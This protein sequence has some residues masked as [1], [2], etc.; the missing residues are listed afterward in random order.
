MKLYSK[1]VLE[2]A[3]I[4]Y[5]WIVDNSLEFMDKIKDKGI[6][7]METFDFSTLYPALTSI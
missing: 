1:T 7:H 3:N 2:R 5:Y 4:N 6:E